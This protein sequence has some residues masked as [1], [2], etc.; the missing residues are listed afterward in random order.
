MCRSCGKFVN[1]KTCQLIYQEVEPVHL[2]TFVILY[3]VLEKN[4]VYSHFFVQIE[5]SINLM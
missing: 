5:F 2:S 3:Y 1:L 4:I